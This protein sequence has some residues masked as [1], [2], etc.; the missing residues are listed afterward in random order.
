MRIIRYLRGGIIPVGE[1]NVEQHG[2]RIVVTCPDIDDNLTALLQSVARDKSVITLHPDSFAEGISEKIIDVKLGNELFWET[3]DHE[4]RKLTSYCLDVN[5]T[6]RIEEQGLPRMHVTNKLQE[7]KSK[8]RSPADAKLRNIVDMALGF[9]AMMRLFEEKSKDKILEQL[10]LQRHRIFDAAT[11][12]EFREAHNE[13]C[14][15]GVNTIKRAERKKGGQVVK[16]GGPASYGQMAKILDVA[17][18]V[19]VHYAHYPD[20][21]KA[22][23]LSKWLNTAMD[24]RMMAFLAGCYPDAL[25]PWPKTIEQVDSREIYET[26][27]DT[28]RRFIQE[29]H[30]WKLTPV[31][32]DDVYWEALNR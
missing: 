21:S 27:Q 28:V 23:S 3:L 9:S 8:R 4:M 26:I 15:W 17:L 22:R 30:Q 24:T 6:E 10:L 19:I 2:N 32:I 14:E 13:F 7:L 16:K 11:L 31:D 12:Y 29:E 5:P 1:I 18:H 25:K 20:C